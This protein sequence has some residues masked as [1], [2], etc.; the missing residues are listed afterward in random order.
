MGLIGANGAG[1]STLLRLASG[2][3]R[4]T[5]G[6]I[7]VSPNVAS[8]LSLGATFN[9]DLTGR[10]NALTAALLAGHADGAGAG[11]GAGGASRSPSWR[12]SPT[13]RC[14]PTATA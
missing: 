9:A 13:R 8:V 4:P 10:E 5:R 1:K 6:E 7:A 11:R 14:A 2:L 3:G 12:S